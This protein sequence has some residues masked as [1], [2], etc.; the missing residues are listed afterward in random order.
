M[1]RSS[2]AS[3]ISMRVFVMATHYI[4][5]T[6]FCGY[7]TSH[8][9][10]QHPLDDLAHG[11]GAAAP[12]EHDA[13]DRL[14]LLMRVRHRDRPADHAERTQVVDVVADVGDVGQADAVLGRP[15]G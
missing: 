5:E 9:A 12:G 8:S 13:G 2:S 4:S 14:H 7:T 11:T 6:A 1:A 15:R 10:R 3:S